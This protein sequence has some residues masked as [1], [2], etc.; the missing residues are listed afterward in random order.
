MT[1]QTDMFADTAKPKIKDFETRV[2]RVL[3]W[4]NDLMAD[5][6]GL[7]ELLDE[8]EDDGA[9]VGIGVIDAAK[10]LVRAETQ[11]LNRVDLRQRFNRQHEFWTRC[12]HFRDPAPSRAIRNPLERLKRSPTKSNVWVD[13][14]QEG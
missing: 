12:M 10:R 5:A 2:K 6:E 14:L 4:T 1:D 8:L 3:R 7:H 13:T 11:R 9:D